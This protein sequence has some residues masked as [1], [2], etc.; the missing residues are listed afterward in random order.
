MSHD[1]LTDVIY[2]VDRG[3]AWIVINRPERYN[4]FRN[5]TIEEIVDCVRRAWA[6]PAVGVIA[7]TGAG[8]KAFSAGG[9]VKQRQETGDYGPSRS[10][11]F[12]LETMHRVLREV[13]KPA[14]AAVNGLAIGGGHVLH[15]LCDVTIASEHARFGQVGPKVGSFDAGFGTAYLARVVGEKRARQI[16]YL[17]EQYD[18]QTALNW[19]LV[20][21]VVPADELRA[22]VRRWADSMLAKSPTALKVIKHS[23][24]A[25]S[26]S[27]A[28]QAQLALD[29]LDL[30]MRTDEAGEGVAAFTEQ[31]PPLFSGPR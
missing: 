4:A 30:Y 23:F 29:T 28:G 3:L 12:E 27:I 7:L 5:R 15:L 10:G 11:L 24:N 9:D 17:C 1:K 13:P 19:G 20:N 2:E 16:W 21:A 8:D 25:A 14:I 6:D 18:A 22:E 26:E 31:R